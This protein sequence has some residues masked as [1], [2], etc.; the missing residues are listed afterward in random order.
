MLFFIF[1][2]FES[3]FHEDLV[4]KM[5][6]PQFSELIGTFFQ[7][8]NDI[9]DIWASDCEKCNY[10]NFEDFC[11]S[12]D[13]EFFQQ[14]DFANVLRE[15][16]KGATELLLNNSNDDI[17]QIFESSEV[18][19]LKFNLLVWYKLENARRPDS[20]NLEVY[21]GVSIAN[22]YIAMCSMK[23]A[24]A[25]KLFQS[26]LFEKCL[27]IMRNCVRTIRMGELIGS[28]NKTTS[29]KRKE[30]GEDE[31]QEEEIA[32]GPPKISSDKAEEYLQTMTTQLFGF[33]SKDSII[34]NNETLIQILEMIEEL[35]RID[36][37]AKSRSQRANSIRE[38]R[39]IER[40]VDRYSAFLHLLAENKYESRKVAVYSRI[41]RPRLALVPFPDENNKTSKIST[42][43]KRAGELAAFFMIARIERKCSAI[44][45]KL[46]QNVIEMIYNQC[47]DLQEFRTS[48]ANFICRIV[49]ILPYKYQYD[50]AQ[51][52]HLFSH[53]K[54]TGVRQ[55]S[56]ELAT[57]MMFGDIDFSRA[58]PG[59]IENE[60][61]DEEEKEEE[62]EEESESD[63]ENDDEEN[64]EE[65]KER[66]KKR[67]EREKSP[68]PEPIERLNAETILYRILYVAC[69]DKTAASRLHGSNSLAKILESEAHREKF[70]EVSREMN[71]QKDA[72]F[73]E[74]N[75]NLEESLEQAEIAANPSTNNKKSSSKTDFAQ[76]E[77]AIIQKL[78]KLKMMNNGEARIEQDTVFML[79]RRLAAD[80]KAPVRK[81][82]C[83]SIRAYLTFCDEREKFEKI[84]GLLETMCRDKMV[85]VRKQSAEILTELMLSENILFKDVMS[86]K[87]LSSLILL[88]DD[89]ENEVQEHARKLIMRVI[90]PLLE[91]TSELTWALLETIET[92]TLHRQYF[93]TT[94]KDAA[95]GRLIRQSVMETMKKHL[96]EGAVNSASAWMVLSQLSVVFKQNVDYAI[97]S[98]YSLDLTQ[99]SK[100][101]KY[102]IHII[103]NNIR[104]IERGQR[105][106][107]CEF[108]MRRLREFSFHASHSKDLYY[109]CAKLMDGIGDQATAKEELKQF[110]E[111]LL[112]SCFDSI[113]E[114]FE[115]F[116]K[117]EEWKRKSEIQERILI[118]ALN[119]ASEIFLFCP[120]LV[121]KHE[122]LAKTLSLIV[123]C[124]TGNSLP[125]VCN[126]DIPSVHNT[127]PPTQMSEHRTIDQFSDVVLFGDN[128]KAAAVLTLANMII[129]HDKMLKLMPMF[130]KQLQHNPSHQ[131]RSNIV[132]ALG[133]ICE[134]YK[135]DRYSPVLAA[136]LCDPSVIVR[137][138]A[139]NEIARMIASSIFRFSG[140][141]MIRLMLAILDANDDVRNDA[142]L[143]ISE[144]LQHEIPNFFPK[145][146]VHYMI[147]LTQAKRM[148]YNNENR[149]KRS[150]R[151][152]VYNFVIES[153]DDRGRFEVKKD[154]CLKVFNAIVNGEFDYSDH[155]VYSLLDD[156]LL[157][158]A[159]NEM[160]VKMEV[161]K[162]SNENGIEEPS[163]E[164]VNAA[165]DFMRTV[166]LQNYMEHIIPSVLRLRE[167]LNQHRSPLQKKCQFVIRM[168]CLEHKNDMDTILRDNRQLKDE[169]VF[170]LQRVKQR[171]E[172]ANRILD[173]H[174]KKIIEFNRMQK[175][176]QQQQEGVES[177]ENEEGME[178]SNGTPKRA[179]N[180]SIQGTPMSARQRPLSPK[181]IKKLRRSIGILMNENQI[182]L[183]PPQL[184]ETEVP[185]NEQVEKE[186]EKEKTVQEEEE[187]EVA[188]TVAEN[189][190]VEE[191]EKTL[192]N[193]EVQGNEPEAEEEAGK[194][195]EEPVESPP[196]RRK[197][198]Q[199]NQEKEEDEKTV[200][201]KPKLAEESPEEPANT[202][203]ANVTLRRKSRRTS[204]IPEVAQENLE[205]RRKTRQRAE[206]PL[207]FDETVLKEGRFCS[208]PIQRRSM[209]DDA[210]EQQ[211]NLNVTFDLNLSAIGKDATR[212]RRT[213]K[214]MADIL[215]AE[216]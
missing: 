206:T 145:H 80:E 179:Q 43:R 35:G 131:I 46:N 147:Y 111:E 137:R 44:E 212:R 64:E 94:L 84:M 118:V 158:M 177:G 138:H 135:T 199:R 68:N 23:G 77:Q 97:D 24:N 211:E 29:K 204:Q 143:Y 82:V 174:L 57:S 123:N 22:I 195:E 6:D 128:V 19:P 153:L 11:E 119:V 98:F 78:K 207:I 76:E 141:V 130:I 32:M 75:E 93:M 1:L 122:R 184:D 55:L 95:N 183:N 88:L 193:E 168:I 186:T 105:K 25:A 113:V 61:E 81:S 106:E 185:P 208:T 187:T 50:F 189:Q 58:D 67:L 49:A 169:M 154:I 149:C 21:E 157:L 116:S 2:K 191:N 214:T 53:C 124:T 72:K 73:G 38:F 205:N 146:F 14:D 150:A 108:M 170:E 63:L 110:S 41:I 85:T 210:E 40:F 37:D 30:E 104:G 136:C 126:P 34:I 99:S 142:R 79:I 117:K 132:V 144:V 166:Y 148:I 197:T 209:A 66:R 125:D 74:I 180:V 100:L 16:N 178:I 70:I 62:E 33:L 4:K 176:Q 112:V 121:P 13:L 120:S 165:T 102:I 52:M 182:A 171:T 173:E 47:P 3:D 15:V 215:E 39:T 12:N 56:I 161:G 48:I 139:I 155:N 45:L 202:S 175:Q 90:A 65:R 83:A 89:N 159:S 26:A 196:R 216:E 114:S 192:V 17:C 172:E 156:A 115:L 5:A 9:A 164:V 160:Q 92:S 71:A 96:E 109:C 163:A 20:S 18:I 194:A 151:I 181:T 10:E 140:E 60:E 162:N 213:K 134:T 167:F 129:A 91:N 36:L 133:D 107:L 152:A 188:E 59:P 198:P 28:N 101:M 69:N 103:T 200:W 127:R 8:C 31:E 190:E 7:Q 203:T 51:T 42:E 201:K 27:K 86:S 54:S 87:W